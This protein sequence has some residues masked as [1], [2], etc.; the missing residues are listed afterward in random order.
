MPDLHVTIAYS[1]TRVDWF[2]VGTSWSPKLEISEG[3]PRQ[4]ERLGEDGR[5]MALLIT[6]NELVWRHRKIVEAGASWDWPD[7][8]PHVSIQIGGD[9]DLSKVE[10]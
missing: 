3:G 10:A 2:K 1:K 6:H 4:M 8:Q 7:Y 9:V 5:Y